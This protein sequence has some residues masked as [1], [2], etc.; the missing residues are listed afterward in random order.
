[1]F[2]QAADELEKRQFEFRHLRRTRVIATAAAAVS[3][4]SLFSPFVVRILD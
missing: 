3:V 1:M 4:V 2:F